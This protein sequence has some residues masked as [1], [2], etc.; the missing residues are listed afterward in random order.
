MTC[1]DKNPSV[2]RADFTAIGTATGPYGGAFVAK[3]HFTWEGYSGDSFKFH[4]HFT[5][6]SGKHTIQ[7]HVFS[8]PHSR[9]TGTCFYF[10]GRNLLLSGPRAEVAGWS[11]CID[12]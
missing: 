1:K 9:N 8:F 11:F 3:G 2:S 7:G 5:I 10:Q 6:T 12:G 4:E